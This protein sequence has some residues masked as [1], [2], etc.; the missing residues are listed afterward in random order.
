VDGS[1]RFNFWRM[2]ICTRA[3][4]PP[5]VMRGLGLQATQ[6][7]WWALLAMACLSVAAVVQLGSRDPAALSN[8]VSNHAPTPA[9]VPKIQ[10]KAPW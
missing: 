9:A 7:S 2:L 5:R 3:V 4:T 1:G 10:P 8:T 6:W